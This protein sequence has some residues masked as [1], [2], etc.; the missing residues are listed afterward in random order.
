MVGHLRPSPALFIT[1]NR[2]NSPMVSDDDLK[3]S[4]LR[5]IEEFNTRQYIHEQIADKRLI[6]VVDEGVLPRTVCHPFKKSLLDPGRLII[7][8]SIR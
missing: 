7:D 2:D 5:R 6:F 1:A 3:E 8:L 4:I